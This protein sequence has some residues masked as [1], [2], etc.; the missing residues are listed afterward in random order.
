MQEVAA[1]AWPKLIP[2]GRRGPVLRPAPASPGVFG[3]DLT[4]GCGH[5]CA[6]CPA[7]PG[8]RAGSED[9]LPFD[10]FT[11]EA[12]AA[13]LD[14]RGDAVRTIVLSPWS[15]PL[16][17]YRPVRAEAVRVAEL[18]LGR[19][20]EL[21]I[22]T[23]GRF[24]RRLVDV[25]AA[26]PHRARV[27]LGFIG[28][29]KGLV[30]ALEP[31]AASPRGRIRDLARLTG[32][33]VPVE[34][35]LEPLIPGLTDTRENLAPLFLELVRAG[36]A[37][38]VAHYL[39]RH[40][41]TLDTLDAALEPL[42]W[43]DRIHEQFEGGPS[44]LV[45]SMGTVRNFPRDLRRDGFARLMAWGAE[46]GLSVTTGA[47]QNPDLPRGE[48]SRRASDAPAETQRGVARKRKPIGAVA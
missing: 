1:R 8:L 15:D 48:P 39:F 11:A 33:G 14:E 40:P 4:A 24:P 44:L 26:H 20:L 29:N 37:R 2:V 17:P 41:A 23:R 27:A 47:A 30:R 21:V 36:A 28:R 22:L 25:L 3:V 19:G 18:V 9:R 10:P 16:P 31:R 7:R 5:G 13:A 34:I 42:G 35:R 38:V 45:G 43:A 6:Y 32:A 12:L 46:F